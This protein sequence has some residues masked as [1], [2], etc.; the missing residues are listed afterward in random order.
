LLKSSDSFLG[1]TNCKRKQEESLAFLFPFCIF[2]HFSIT[3]NPRR[4]GLIDNLFTRR[5]RG[6]HPLKETA[7]T[8]RADH[9]PGS[10]EVFILTID[11]N[12]FSRTPPKTRT[13]NDPLD[14]PVA[15]TV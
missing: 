8:H 6:N 10:N 12:N 4:T 7:E 2:S 13:H 9:L 3:W 11:D 1:L 14:T 15:R 5:D